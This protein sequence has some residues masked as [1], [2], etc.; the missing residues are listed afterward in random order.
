MNSSWVKDTDQN[1]SARSLTS[2]IFAVGSALCSRPQPEHESVMPLLSLFPLNVLTLY[3]LS[4]NMF[5][6][7]FASYFLCIQAFNNNVI[8]NG[9][10]CCCNDTVTD[11]RFTSLLAK[12][13]LR[14]IQ[15]IFMLLK[16]A[17]H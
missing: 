16:S 14:R 10:S 9:N 4:E 5:R 1:T 12:K 6:K 7:W 2:L 3:L 15:I 8:S 13:Y 17:F 11:A